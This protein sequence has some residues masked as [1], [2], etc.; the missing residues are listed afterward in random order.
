MGADWRRDLQF[1]IPVRD[2]SHWQR[3]EI[4]DGLASTLRF[5]SDDNYDFD[6]QLAGNAASS[7]EYLS[8]DEA[9]AT[10]FQPDEVVL[11]SGGLDSLA[12][13]VE[14]LA[15]SSK[16]LA[17]ISHRPSSKIYD[18]QKRLVAAL[19]DA[20]PK[21]VMH[22]PVLINRQNPLPVK[23]YTQRTRSF[24]YA[25]V[26]A[27]IAHMFGL[28][29]VRFFENGVISMN[30][31]IAEQVIGTRATRTT[32]PLTLSMLA[33]LMS[34][35]LE[36]PFV[37]E[38]PFIWNT[39]AEVVGKIARHGFGGLIR[40]TVSCS[41][42]QEMSHAHTHCGCCSQ[43]IDRR[44]GV[45]AAGLERYDPPELYK[46]DLLEGARERGIDR[47]M[48]ESY[49]RTHVEMRSMSPLSFAGRYGGELGRICLAASTIPSEQVAQRVMDLHWRHGN[50]VAGVLERALHTLGP[51]LV[52]GELPATSIVR[53]ALVPSEERKAIPD[54]SERWLDQEAS[55]YPDAGIAAPPLGGNRKPKSTPSRDRAER[56]IRKL[57]P[58]GLP[59]ATDLPNKLLC[60]QVSDS[61]GTGPLR[62]SDDTIL[63]A[64]LRRI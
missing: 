64:A 44:F 51:K 37:V 58:K 15:T 56:A 53:M 34:S 63:R 59:D 3:Q 31:P 49:V 19:K 46:V 40:H 14:E 25:S 47:T 27:A 30:L 23:E 60:K 10:A 50:E 16:R 5:L 4:C 55:Q 17:L 2:A 38:N 22:I 8:W 18:H 57:Y 48:A 9:D 35:V 11:F 62:V 12:G 29:G 42:V 7:P 26:A 6:F 43:C 54:A 41:K 36:S 39:K 13:A 21:R 61:I 1:V 33:T 52:R 24:L 32:H 20:F 28:G 45:L